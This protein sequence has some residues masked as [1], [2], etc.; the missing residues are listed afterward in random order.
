MRVAISLIDGAVVAADERSAKLLKKLQPGEVY[1][2]L[3]DGE[4]VRSNPQNARYWAQIHKLASVIPET[5]QAA[6]ARNMLDAL[7][8]EQIDEDT[9]H[10]Y[11]KMRVGVS[12]ISFDKMNHA[13]AC[14]FYRL[15]D[16]EIER[17]TAL[18]EEMR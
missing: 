8:L 2:C 10:A 1:D 7:T 14:E 9:L 12:S 6:F 13:E 15:A 18:A 17:M 16:D 4:R 5:F 11:I 3:I